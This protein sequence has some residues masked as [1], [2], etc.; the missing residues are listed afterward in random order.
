VLTS[1]A[2]TNG[3]V[4][5]QH[6][7]LF[8]QCCLSHAKGNYEMLLRFDGL[9]EWQTDPVVK[10]SGRVHSAA[11]YVQLD[12]TSVS[13]FAPVSHDHDCEEDRLLGCNKV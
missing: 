7:M 9:N 11:S 4:A 6:I 10:S 8:E 5:Q 3:E 1:D 12:P 2:D 13:A